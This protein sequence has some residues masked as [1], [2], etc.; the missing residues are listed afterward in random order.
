[1]N[2]IVLFII[3]IKHKSNERL[4]N[5]LSALIEAQEHNTLITKIKGEKVSNYSSTGRSNTSLWT[6]RSR[7][8]S[9]D[10]W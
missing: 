8:V 6:E 4:P 3:Y 5:A 1:M 7:I 2:N 9:G 10:P